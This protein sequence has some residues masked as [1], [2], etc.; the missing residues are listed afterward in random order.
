[1]IMCYSMLELLELCSITRLVITK[2]SETWCVGMTLSSAE[3]HKYCVF[4]AL[5]VCCHT[6]REYSE[7]E[8]YMCLHLLHLFEYIYANKN[9]K[10]VLTVFNSCSPF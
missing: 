6:Q 7:H 9:S 10:I 3:W 2:F 4:V 1:M 5:C 8:I